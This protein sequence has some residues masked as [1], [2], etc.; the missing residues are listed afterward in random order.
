MIAEKITE[1][2]T[3]VGSSRCRGLCE[4]RMIN[5]NAEKRIAGMNIDEGD[6]LIYTEL[7]LRPRLLYPAKPCACSTL[8]ICR[9]GLG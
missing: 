5:V 8:D 3:G 9:Y 7:P 6:G 1:L 4:V 2:F